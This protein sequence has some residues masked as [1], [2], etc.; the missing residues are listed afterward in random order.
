MFSHAYRQQQENLDYLSLI[1]FYGLPL[2]YLDDFVGRVDKV[3]VAQIRDA[4][5]RHVNP[6][7]LATVIV[8]APEVKAESGK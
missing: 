7:A 1:G 5:K 6:D 2:T 4:F 8:G 3:T